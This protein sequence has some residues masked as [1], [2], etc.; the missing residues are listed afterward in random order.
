MFISSASLKEFWE[1]IEN[2]KLTML[3]VILV[4]LR[5]ENHALNVITYY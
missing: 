1:L 2:M 3:C 5:K 4:N